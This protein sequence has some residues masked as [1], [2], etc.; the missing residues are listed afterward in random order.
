MITSIGI[1]ANPNQVFYCVLNSVDEEIT[2]KLIDKIVI[3]KLLDVPEQLKF[4]R[5]TLR[6]IIN[7]NQAIHACIRI[8]EANARKVSIPRIYMEGVVQ[9]LIASSTIEKYF[10]GQI[11]SISSKLEI[12][13][14]EFKPYAQGLN[15]FMEID[16]WP[17]LSQEERESVMAS[18]SALKL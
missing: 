1:R 14:E 13:R 18:F 12:D 11:S 3:P 7:E 16:I 9:E 5:S 10:V 2:I 15:V 4:L 6:D 17:N 8:T